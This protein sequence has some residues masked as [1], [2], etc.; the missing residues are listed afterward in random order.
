M[1]VVM[2]MITMMMVPGPSF[3]SLHL[4]KGVWQFPLLLVV[5]VDEVLA[6]LGGQA[7]STPDP[8]IVHQAGGQGTWLS[9][10]K[11]MTM[12]LRRTTRFLPRRAQVNQ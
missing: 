7:R 11:M 10:M 3:A 12:M 4:I 2:M 1:M 5:G 6:H 8:E 9:K